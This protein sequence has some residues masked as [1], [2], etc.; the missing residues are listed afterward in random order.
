VREDEADFS[1]RE[2][3]T[4]LALLIDTC[5]WIQRRTDR[6][7]LID[8]FTVR[9][10]ILFE[11]ELPMWAQ[12]AARQA[13][14]RLILPVA[15]MGGGSALRNLE[16]TVGQEP[17]GTLTRRGGDRLTGLIRERLRKN[18]DL[19]IPEQ[20]SSFVDHL[21]R[22]EPDSSGSNGNKSL[23]NR[24]YI[25]YV[26]TDKQISEEQD[27]AGAR[28]SL[29]VGTDQTI[30]RELE[31]QPASIA[32]TLRAIGLGR[33]AKDAEENPTNK[34]PA[35]KDPAE[36]TQSNEPTRGPGKIGRLR[37]FWTNLF[38]TNTAFVVAQPISGFG[39]AQSWQLEIYAPDEL[40]ITDGALVYWPDTEVQ[41]GAWSE[42]EKLNKQLRR[43][44][45]APTTQRGSTAV[46][47]TRFRIS[48]ESMTHIGMLIGGASVTLLFAAIFIA[49]Y[50]G[51]NEIVDAVVAILIIAPSLGAS[52][53]T[54]PDSHEMAGQ[55]LR[56]YRQ[57]IYSI[58][59]ASAVGAAAFI[60]FGLASDDLAPSSKSGNGAFQVINNIMESLPK[61]P[62]VFAVIALVAMVG[63]LLFLALTFWRLHR[64]TKDQEERSERSKHF[65]SSDINDLDLNAFLEST[66]DPRRKIKSLDQWEK[67]RATMK[68]RGESV[69]DLS[70]S[71]DA[72]D[73]GPRA[74]FRIPPNTA[75]E[76]TDWDWRIVKGKKAGLR[77]WKYLGLF[78]RFYNSEWTGDVPPDWFYWTG[79]IDP[80]YTPDTNFYPGERPDLLKIRDDL[81]EGEEA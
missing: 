75:R 55:Y 50:G 15:I 13:D 27:L 80:D 11:I 40:R 12:L 69:P 31:T 52:I 17:A 48:A 59:V 1:Q 43:S 7:H 14:C 58:G 32:K 81:L 4:S 41:E 37:K 24:N 34:N 35:D 6:I 49:L 60:L 33:V 20:T 18:G 46:A 44:K 76:L 79:D 77:S 22:M 16:V 36:E 56:P 28:F 72:L 2:I 26:T 74:I 71:I 78:N 3:D 61:T 64:M 66:D 29:T 63:A 21:L 19:G 62:A 23:K 68:R 51:G 47:L 45:N 10:S 53:V 30:V 8:T 65:L 38:P 57:R 70:V 25:L 9:R 42:S 67:D 5:A 73:I 54:N 39:D